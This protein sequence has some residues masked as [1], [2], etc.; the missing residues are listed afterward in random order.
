MYI[1]ALKAGCSEQFY[2]E[3]AKG[4]LLFSDA[5]PYVG[6]RYLIPKPIR[7]VEPVEKGNSNNKKKYKNLKYIPIESL[8]TYLSGGM[9][10]DENLMKDFG[11]SSPRNMARV[12]TSEDTLPFHVGTYYFAE[13]NGLYL[14][15]AYQNEESL[16]L[17]QA[18]L[19]AVS[20]VGIGGKRTSGLGKFTVKKGQ[21]NEELNRRLQKET[22]CS[23]LLSVAYPV[24]EDLEKTLEGASYLLE[25]RSGFIESDT[26]AEEL[27]KKKDMYVF[28]AGSCFQNRFAGGIYDVSDGGRHPVYRYAMPLFLGV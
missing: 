15:V 26:Y 6:D 12:R 3:V 8:T 1:E 16:K 11:K 10:A 2:E 27:R 28:A 23:M 18:L 25:K 14:V 19:E 13:G 4:N 5:M 7:Y 24:D 21:D 22:T 9:S 17:A 20:Y